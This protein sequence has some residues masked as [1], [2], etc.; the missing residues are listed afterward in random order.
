MNNADTD[1][2]ATFRQSTLTILQQQEDCRAVLEQFLVLEPS[3][4]SLGAM[5]AMGWTGICQFMSRG[6]YRIPPS[7][8]DWHEAL[9]LN[10]DQTPKHLLLAE[11]ADFDLRADV[12]FAS[13]L[14]DHRER[15]RAAAAFYRLAGGTNQGVDSMFRVWCRRSLMVEML[16]CSEYLNDLQKRQFSV[17]LSAL[18]FVGPCFVESLVAASPKILGS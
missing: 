15:L 14:N 17:T 6:G 12:Y 16:K 5:R 1:L 11:V 13:E 8:S 10:W 18:D 2:R 3:G 9:G 4:D 7:S